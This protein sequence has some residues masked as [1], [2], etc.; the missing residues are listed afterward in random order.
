MLWRKIFGVSKYPGSHGC[1]ITNLITDMPS[2][3]RA[4]IR[5]LLAFD[6]RR[7]T[8]SLMRPTRAWPSFGKWLRCMA[9]RLRSVMLWVAGRRRC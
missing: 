8:L 6:L 2:N 9:A 5:R 1:F 7:M 4:C 3:R